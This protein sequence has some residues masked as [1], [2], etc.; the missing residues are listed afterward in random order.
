[1]M[2]TMGAQA[3]QFDDDHRSTAIVPRSVRLARL[4]LFRSPP[5]ALERLELAIG[6]ELARFLVAALASSQDRV[7][8]SSPYTRT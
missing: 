2:N 3:E 7:G 8:S 4:V 6:V 5:T 1:M